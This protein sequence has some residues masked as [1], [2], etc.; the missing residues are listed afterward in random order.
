M[1]C[2]H[3]YLYNHLKHHPRDH[4]DIHHRSCLVISIWSLHPFGNHIL[5]NWNVTTGC[6][7]LD[8]PAV[9]GLLNFWANSGVNHSLHCNVRLAISCTEGLNYWNPISHAESTTK[10][11]ALYFWDILGLVWVFYCAG[12]YNQNSSLTG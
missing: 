4:I 6:Q 7:P 11:L 12:I 10:N 5:S 3:Y 9:P 8:R 2:C 1:I